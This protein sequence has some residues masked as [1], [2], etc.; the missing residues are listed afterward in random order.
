MKFDVHNLIYEVTSV[1]KRTVVLCASTDGILG[2][3]TSYYDN[4]PNINNN[5]LIL[6]IPPAVIYSNTEYSVVGIKEDVLCNLTMLQELRLP[7]T[8][9]NFEWCLWGCDN[10]I[11]IIVDENNKKLMSI[12]GVLFE[13]KGQM[14]H[15]L[16]AFPLGRNGKYKIPEFV[17]HIES[18][19]FKCCK[20]NELELP[21]KLETIGNNVFYR[22]Y[23][24]K[25][26]VLPYSLKKIGKC[27]DDTFVIFKYKGVSYKSNEICT[28]VS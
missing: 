26:V 3:L 19:A 9:E 22:C 25:E 24:L 23:N 7:A 21:T 20:I 5:D 17:K 28:A 4:M 1:E 11:N 10:L 14:P 16:L 13:K 27:Q 8:L 6:E 12:D 2:D 15:K 18:K